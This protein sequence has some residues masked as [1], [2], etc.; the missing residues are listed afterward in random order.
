MEEKA[1]MQANMTVPSILA[2]TTSRA[3]VSKEFLRDVAALAGLS[4]GALFGVL[5]LSLGLNSWLVKVM[6]GGKIKPKG[7]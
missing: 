2:G 4:A 5:G 6:S 7:R 1:R 3:K